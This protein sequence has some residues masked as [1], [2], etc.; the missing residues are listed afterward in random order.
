MENVNQVIAGILSQNDTIQGGSKRRSSS[1]SPRRR[2]ILPKVRSHRRSGMLGLGVASK[3]SLLNK[4]TLGLLGGSTNSAVAEVEGGR[5]RSHK[6][7]HSRRHSRS[8]SHARGGSTEPE[9]SGGSAAGAAAI[10]GGS[11]PAAPAAISG[12]SAPAD[13]SAG[14]APAADAIT[15]GS[16]PAAPAAPADVAGGSSSD[17]TAPAD[18]SGGRKHRKHSRSRSRRHHKHSHRRSHRRSARGGSTDATEATE[19][20]GGSCGAAGA[21]NGAVS[22]GRMRFWGGSTEASVEGGRKK[23]SLSPK[24]RAHLA[25]QMERYR[26]IKRQHP[27]MP[28][29]EAL[30]LAMMGRRA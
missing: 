27:N 18:V 13:G 15:G 24:L 19:I 25:A 1:R 8:R 20:A 5:K 4:V 9:V 17:A 6:R 10:A 16:A 7:R 14:A 26:A 29:N 30:K 2:S 28:G 12:G 3:G 23:R 22:G 11:A 21:G